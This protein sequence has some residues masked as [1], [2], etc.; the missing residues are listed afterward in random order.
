V[1]GKLVSL[2][3]A[4]ALGRVDPERVRDLEVG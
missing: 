4:A 1:S 3:D 2:A